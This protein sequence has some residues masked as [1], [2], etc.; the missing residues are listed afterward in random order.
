MEFSKPPKSFDE[1]IQLLVDR[2]LT[3]DCV[4]TAKTYLSHSNYY[5]LRAYWHS[6]ES[7]H[8]THEFRKGSTFGEAVNLYEFD[9]KLRILILNAIERIEVS[10]RTQWAYQLAHQH[11]SH[12]YI[13]NNLYFDQD[14]LSELLEKIETEIDRSDEEFIKHYKKT[15]TTP[16]LPPIW[17]VCEVISLGSLSKFYSNIKIFKLKKSISRA[18]ELDDVVLEK[19]LHHLSHVRNICAH[20]SRLWNRKFTV[21]LRPPRKMPVWLPKCF[22]LDSSSERKIYNTLVM[23]EYLL[24][25]ITVE[26]NFKNDLF[27]I[28]SEHD[29]SVDQMGFP[30]DYLNLRIWAE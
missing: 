3:I 27:S 16:S 24:N 1:Q 11:G 23:I 21:L 29:I 26:N 9:R 10:F 4:E 12:S 6:L 20:H 18:Y 17:A 8:A 14:H 22:N 28:I 2:G 5:R 30:D 7:N 19:F 25:L 15:Y 13:D